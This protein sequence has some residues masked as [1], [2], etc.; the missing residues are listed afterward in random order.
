MRRKENQPERERYFQ[1]TFYLLLRLMSVYTV[2]VEK[3][4]SEGRW[5][6]LSKHPTSCTSSNS[7]WTERLKRLCS[8]LKIRAMHVPTKL[9]HEP[10]IK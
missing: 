3:E 4:Q 7:N 6:V 9:M 8:K 5:T 2:Y 1:Y 10:C